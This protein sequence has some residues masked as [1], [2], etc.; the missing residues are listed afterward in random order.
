MSD[1][2]GLYRGVYSAMLDHPDYQTL[3]SAARLTLLTLRLCT[4]NTV[5]SIFRYYPT[6]LRVQTGQTPKVLEGSLV[7]LETGHWI[8]RDGVVL[9]IRNGLRY[10]PYIRLGDPKHRTAVLRAISALPTCG[11]VSKFCDYY[12][13]TRPSE[14]SSKGHA[15]VIDDPSPPSPIPI[16]SP[17]R[18]TTTGATT[19]PDD[20]SI[21]RIGEP[22]PDAAFQSLVAQVSARMGFRP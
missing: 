15:R 5:A 8:E 6:Q 22:A 12:K 18:K 1:R 9:W 13:I 3:S 17:R 4:Q 10:D 2:R 14:G 16:P 21:T 19:M 7:E 11:L 20:L